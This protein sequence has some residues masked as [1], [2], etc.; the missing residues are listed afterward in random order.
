M[1]YGSQFKSAGD[2]STQYSLQQLAVPQAL[3]KIPSHVIINSNMQHTL[4]ANSKNINKKYCMFLYFFP[5][6]S[7][8]MLFCLVYSCTMFMLNKK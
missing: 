7:F 5:F 4:C 3:R 2:Q 1:Y 6:F 8:C